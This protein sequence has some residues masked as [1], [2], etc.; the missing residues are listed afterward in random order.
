MEYFGSL[1]YPGVGPPLTTVDANRC[2][3]V[4]GLGPGLDETVPR[5]P[6]TVQKCKKENKND[7]VIY[8]SIQ[9]G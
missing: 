4:K 9:K 1:H 3:W 2:G 8:L 5:D 6:L 7:G